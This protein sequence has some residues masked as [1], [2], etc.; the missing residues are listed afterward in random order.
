M[1]TVIETHKLTKF[2]GKSRGILDVDLSVYEGEIFGLIGPNGA[3]KSTLI[4]TLLSLIYK[5]EGEA[6]VFGLDCHRDKTKILEQVGYLPGEVF[7]YENMKAIDLLR[8][9]ASFYKRDCTDKIQELAGLLELDLS[10]KIE[11]MSLGNKKKVGIVQ[12]LLHSPKLIIMDEP[13]SGLDPLM[14]KTFFELIR[15]ENRNGATV[16]FSSHILSEVQR[17]C[18]RVGI[19]REGK[20]IDIQKISDLQKNTYKKV[21]FSVKENIND[22]VVEGA[23]DIAIRDNIVSFIFKGDCNT[24][25]RTISGYPVLDVEISEPTLDE[26]FL[27]YYE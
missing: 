16:L 15:K 1:N 5:T 9:S 14:Q 26:V 22:F 18:S 3:G 21:V 23:R 11:D 12:G 6:T 8:Y 19:I 25:L 27:H 24:L 17:I 13:T 4:R 2:Y 20:M 10:R 7:Y